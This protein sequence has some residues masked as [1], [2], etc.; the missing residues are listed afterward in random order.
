MR[1]RA[2]SI[3]R[4]PNVL[5]LLAEKSFPPGHLRVES[6]VLRLEAWKVSGAIRVNKHNCKDCPKADGKQR[7]NGIENR[8]EA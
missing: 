6:T 5:T 8:C 1:G 7:L 2:Q 3:D 4:S